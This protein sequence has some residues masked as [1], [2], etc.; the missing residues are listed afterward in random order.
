MN[1][2]VLHTEGCPSLAPLV[3]ELQRLMDGRRDVTVT[4]VP[5][6]SDDEA[7]RLGFHGSPTI[8]VDGKDP[9][10]A[11]PEP[12]GLSC[13]TY[14]SGADAAGRVPGIPTHQQLVEVIQLR[15]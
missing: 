4:T 11:P 9:F 7:S 3:A 8:L 12:V 15:R 5:V 1:V 2:T 10:P 6:R 13:R 14:P